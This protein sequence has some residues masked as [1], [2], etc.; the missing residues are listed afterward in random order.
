[1][2][3]VRSWRRRDGETERRRAFEDAADLLEELMVYGIYE[4]YI[5][6]EIAREVIGIVRA[7]GKHD[8]K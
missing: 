2:I 4:I 1:M 5:D 8:E 7:G 6:T 3:S